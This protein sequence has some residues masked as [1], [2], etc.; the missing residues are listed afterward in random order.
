VG[1]TRSQQLPSVNGGA[2]YSALQIPSSL[3]SKNSD[4]GSAN[5]FFNGGVSQPVFRI[6]SGSIECLAAILFLIPRTARLGAAIIAMFMVGALLSH[7]FVLG[8]GWVFVDALAIFA[9]PCL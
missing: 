9:L 4:G 5:S 3:A 2:S 1:I 8:Y 6:G 7:V